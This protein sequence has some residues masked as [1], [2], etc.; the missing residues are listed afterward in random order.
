MIHKNG[1]VR[2]LC[3]VVALLLTISAAP[4]GA[5][6]WI[7][8]PV[9]VRDGLADNFV[10]DI[11]TDS[12][13]YVWLST[14]NG[15]SR[16]DGYRFLNFH[17]QQWGGRSGDVTLVRETADGTLWAISSDELFTYHRDSQTWHKDGAERLRQAGIEASEKLQV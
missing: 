9:D 17:P 7:F 4:K 11:T 15:L 5:G 10:R 1:Y 2:I 13:G 12:E 16:Y 14:I 6:R 8:H 3:T